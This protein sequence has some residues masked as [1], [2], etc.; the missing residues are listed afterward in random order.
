MCQEGYVKKGVSKRE[1]LKEGTVRDR[2]VLW[3]V[4]RRAVLRGL[5][6]SW[7]QKKVRGKNFNRNQSLCVLY[8]LEKTIVML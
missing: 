2:W 7:S 1:G 3:G 5:C 4:A 6:R 8:K